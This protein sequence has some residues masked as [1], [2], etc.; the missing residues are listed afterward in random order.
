MY[1]KQ[2]MADALS[3]IL[4]IIGLRKAGIENW[5]KYTIVRVRMSL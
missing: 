5:V 4:F 1:K 2:A 3:A